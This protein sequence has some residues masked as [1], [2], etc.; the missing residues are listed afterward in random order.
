MIMKTKKFTIALLLLAFTSPLLQAADINDD[1]DALRIRLKNDFRRA[2][3][4][5]AGNYEENIYGWVQGAMIDA[6]SHY[7]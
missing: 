7:N 4:P 1:E 2:D 3:R 5:S 6:N